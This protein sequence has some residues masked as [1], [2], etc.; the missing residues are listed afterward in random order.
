MGNSNTRLLVKVS[1]QYFEDGLTQQEIAESLRISRSAVSRLLSRARAEEI[2]HISIKSPPGIYPQLERALEERFGLLEAVVLD[3]GDHSHPESVRRDLGVA[4]ADYL[5]R[6]V[7]PGDVVGLAWG[8]TIKAM[9]DALPSR[10]IAGLKV[11]QMVGGVSERVTEVHAM[12]LAREL[13]AR[14]GGEFYNLQAPGVVDDYRNRETFLADAQV[15]RVFDMAEGADLAFV[16]LGALSRDT[17][18]GKAG[19]LTPALLRE[20]EQAGA[21][22]EVLLRYYDRAGAPVRSSLDRRVI[23]LPLERLRRVGRVVGIGGGL[24]KLEAILGALAGR[25]VHVLITDQ[26]TAHGLLQALPGD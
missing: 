2:V 8:K 12:E 20:L 23:G 4:A 1:K 5:L 19:I 11:V 14:L 22:G 6:T 9:V 10:K 25:Y 21:V 17:M 24:P 13:A 3:A 7:Q 15:R 18:M 26:A 16:G